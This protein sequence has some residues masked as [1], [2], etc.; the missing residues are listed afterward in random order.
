MR[1]T[2]TKNIS[3]H[4]IQGSTDVWISTLGIVPVTYK[5]LYH[6]Y[7]DKYANIAVFMFNGAKFD[8]DSLFYTVSNY[9]YDPAFSNYDKTAPRSYVTFTLIPHI[10]IANVKNT[11]ATNL[12]FDESTNTVTSVLLKHDLNNTNFAPALYTPVQKDTSFMSRGESLAISAKDPKQV[13]LVVNLGENLRCGDVVILTQNGVNYYYEI[14][15][16]KQLRLIQFDTY[17]YRPD[18]TNQ[19]V[20]FLMLYNIQ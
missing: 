8:L 4:G 11:F 20:Y 3:L 5:S 15:A 13:G 6:Y 7:Q 12:Y 1:S 10:F 17:D 18:T 9:Y 2:D 14:I 16:T 19:S